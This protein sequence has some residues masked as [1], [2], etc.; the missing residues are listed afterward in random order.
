[1]VEEVGTVQSV[2]GLLAR[3]RV[4]RKSTCEGCTMG[5]CKTDEQG[6]EIEAVNQAGA[7]V[8]QRVK[9]SIQTFTYVRGTMVVYG[10]PAVLL[11]AG[12]V[13]GKEF[14]SRIFTHTDPDILSAVFGFAAFFISFIVVKLWSHAASRDTRSRPVVEEILS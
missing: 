4:P 11:V 6:M 12:A 1:M 14:M 8:G 5:I 2:D 7:R 10:L 13:V 9:V 3:V